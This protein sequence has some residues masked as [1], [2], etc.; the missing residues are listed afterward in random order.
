MRPLSSTGWSGMRQFQL[1]AA[2][3]QAQQ[4][5][6]GRRDRGVRE[7]AEG[8]GDP[9]QRPD[10]DDI[11]DRDREVGAPLGDPQ[12]LHEA[13]FVGFRKCQTREI[14]QQFVKDRV[15]PVS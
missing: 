4:V 13:G 12:R 10:A 1:A 9:L 3:G 11:G 8:A 5:G 14:V 15:R 7:I 2:M 6:G